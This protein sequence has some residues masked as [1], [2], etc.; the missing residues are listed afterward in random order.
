ME[1]SS[2]LVNE[3]EPELAPLVC[4][5]CATEI[6]HE[7]WP[8]DCPRCQRPLDLQ[9]QFA[10][11]R[12]HNAFTVGQDLVF[13]AYQKKRK[14]RLPSQSEKEGLECY[15]QAYS[16]LQQAFQGELAESQRQLGTQMMAA[17][18]QVF[19][20]NTMV[21]PLE[22]AYWSTLLVEMNSRQERASLR[23]KLAQPNT[24][25]VIGLPLRLRWRLRIH[26]LEKALVELKQ[27][28]RFLEHSIGFAGVSPA[29]K[30]EKI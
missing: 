19:Q 1:T 8:Q 28:L 29:P 6:D 26:Q 3:V 17:I 12:G 13:S 10:Y 15:M 25:G 2:A 24:R 20:V 27:K 11:C 7:P 4:P 18:V 22:A 16:A 30:K 9:A 23:E 14:K 5:R 21:S